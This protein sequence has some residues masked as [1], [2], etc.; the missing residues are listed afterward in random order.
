MKKLIYKTKFVLTDIRGTSA[1]DYA[2]LVTGIAAALIFVFLILTDTL[3]Q[4]FLFIANILNNA[5]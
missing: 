5:F 4:A 3:N 2:L 1:M